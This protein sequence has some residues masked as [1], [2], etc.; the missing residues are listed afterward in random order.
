MVRQQVSE[1]KKK[2]LRQAKENFLDLFFSS[3][4]LWFC[5]V[6]LFLFLLF[7]YRF[8]P[9]SIGF[10]IEWNIRAAVCC[11]FCYTMCRDEK[12]V[13]RLV[14][15]L[16][17]LWLST[18]E[19]KPTKKFVRFV[20]THARSA[21]TQPIAYGYIDSLTPTVHVLYTYLRLVSHCSSYYFALHDLKT[22]LRKW[23]ADTEEK[24]IAKYMLNIVFGR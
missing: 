16:V 21:D 6:W 8:F 23:K 17:P 24:I 7:C 13:N 14:V 9:Y 1:R 20:C 18:A 19:S 10:G 15:M 4:Y 3:H 12:Q 2:K 5:Y 22:K 11:C